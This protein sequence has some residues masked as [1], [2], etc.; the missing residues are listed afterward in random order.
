MGVKLDMLK[1]EEIKRIAKARGGP[2]TEEDAAFITSMSME[3]AVDPFSVFEEGFAKE[4][5][6]SID[7]AFPTDP[8]D[9]Q[10]FSW[11]EEA[12]REAPSAV[13]LYRKTAQGLV[14]KREYSLKEYE[15][16][17]EGVQ[18]QSWAG[19]GVDQAKNMFP[20]YYPVKMRGLTEEVPFTYPGLTGDTIAA[21][22][23]S[24]LGLPFEEFKVKYTEVLDRLQEDNPSLALI[25][26]S[27]VIGRSSDERHV[28][29]A[30]D[31]IDTLALGGIPKAIRASRNLIEVRRAF[32]DLVKANGTKDTDRGAILAATGN[33]KEA[34]VF[35]VADDII[36]GMAETTPDVTR[37]ILSDLPEFFQT[38]A[39]EIQAA[40]GSMREAAVRL[41]NATATQGA[42]L[43]RL[44]AEQGGVTRVGTRE[45]LEA[46][47]R[48]I[49]KDLENQFPGLN[50]SYIN[51]SAPLRD[52]VT[53][54]LHVQFKFGDQ[55]A[56]YFLDRETAH[57][58]ATLNKLTN[59]EVK[60]DGRGFY[61]AIEKPFKETD[62]IVRDGLIETG[63]T[64]TPT[65]LFGMF[66][67]GRTPDDTLSKLQNENRK[68]STYVPQSFL[69]FVKDTSENIR[70]MRKGVTELDAQGNRVSANLFGNKKRMR[71]WER[72]V[73]LG[74]TLD[75]KD[76]PGMKGYFYKS[77]MEFEE[78]F[79]QNIGRMPSQVETAAYFE[80]V[81]LHEIDRV[82]RASADYRNKSRV[83][84]EKHNFGF[85]D[86]EGKVVRSPDFEGVR[87]SKLP[88][89]SEGVI[90]IVGKTL[91]ETQVKQVDGL[92]KA[93]AKELKDGVKE[94]RL[95]VIEVYAPE[96][97]VFEG[98]AGDARVRWVVTN[99]LETKP[100]SWNDQVPRRG[101]GHWEYDYDFYI[102]Q[103][104]M[105]E[106]PFKNI[107][108]KWYEGDTTVMPMSIRA[109]GVEVSKHLDEVR[110]LL[111]AGK[112]K[113]AE[114]YAKANLHVAPKEVLS[115]FKPSMLNGKKK[116]PRLNLD[117][118]IQLVPKD[119]MIV[120]IDNTLKARHGAAF[121]D[122]TT[123]GSLNK[124][125]QVQF[126]GERD[127]YELTTLVDNGTR[128]KPLYA[129]EP[130][131]M[132]DPMPMMNRALQR[133]VN[134][135]FMDDYKT[136]SVE[137][138]IKEAEN[139]L[140][141]NKADLRAN[142][143]FHFHNPRFLNGAPQD[144]VDALKGAHYQIE[145]LIGKPT[146]L[147][148]Q[149]HSVSQKL[150]DSIYERVGGRAALLTDAAL[151]KTKDPYTYARSMAFHA[152]LGL[153][154]WVQL[155]V[156][157]Q[158]MAHI[159]A[160]AGPR[161]AVSGSAASVA[162]L[163]VRRNM[164]PEIMKFYDDALVKMS[165]PGMVAWKPGEFTEAIRTLDQTGFRHVQMGPL[166][167][168]D[169]AANPRIVQGA[170]GNFLD[171]GTGFFRTGEKAVRN[172]AWF[173]AYKEF[174]RDNPTKR[175]TNQVRNQILN[176]A[177]DL[178]VNMS[179]ASNSALHKGIFSIPFQFLTYQLRLMEQMLPF[180]GKRLTTAEKARVYAV[181]GGLYGFP[182]ATNVTGVPFGDFIRKAALE[183]NVDVHESWIQGALDGLPSMVLSLVTGKQYNVGDRFGIQ[184][185]ET[186]REF[187]RGDRPWWELAGGAAFSTLRDT[188]GHSDGFVQAMFSAIRGDGEFDFQLEDFVDP[189]K[190]I[191]TVNNA[192]RGLAAIHTG[193][194]MSRKEIYLS[195]VSAA[196]AFFMTAV[197][198]QPQQVADMHLMS[199]AMKDQKE[200]E[201]HVTK[202][203][204]L[205]FRRGLDARKVGNLEQANAYMKRAF[206]YLHIGGLRQDMW[207]AAISRATQGNESLIESMEWDFYQEKVSPE[208]QEGAKEQLMRNMQ[209]RQGEQ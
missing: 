153:F 53:N 117:E 46:G 180:A 48:A 30:F 107:I 182:V 15:K 152:K 189:F 203:F 84:T 12:K 8:D 113:D 104:K 100:L 160:V 155:L 83:G 133:I 82:L 29:N 90:M 173:S 170:V 124:Q 91:K 54:T 112:T 47:V 37:R 172:V 97:R 139:F 162:A 129:W 151:S 190:A 178:Y 131:K 119:K 206:V 135:R 31:L 121:R 3:Q 79:Q 98:I 122:G 110:K 24:L 106:E 164:S 140:D 195:D 108:R 38:M 20:W 126:T 144:K 128:G 168:I 66:T 185:F 202:Q 163:L 199:W 171:A 56:G 137:H 193:R 158:S 196:N 208:R 181:Y 92:S 194:W 80:H 138:W 60:G 109:Q 205:E 13:D 71:E 76:N 43:T 101:G 149:L 115:W 87:R 10:P 187:T 19:W 134:S 49:Q 179:R 32:K 26:A 4:F 57:M 17:Y 77:P 127:S 204:V 142:P 191:S 51:A 36:E 70:A 175:I 146:T 72:V 88:L 42:K 27:E 52:P 62:N 157:M 192:W 67:K 99:S 118:P 61:V 86:E 65:S 161:M 34:A 132:V 167:M 209:R 166:A 63:Q 45:A 14:A 165:Y 177:D 125:N 85:I 120:D 159:T 55:N 116:P 58:S 22:A 148:A 207:P 64:D 94:G 186:L 81:R 123:R 102:K 95:Q 176:R 16:R 69:E 183:N 41:A 89:G 28:D 23:T 7:T 200:L 197:G 141:V 114:A 130:A 136:F 174:R 6:N 111:K 75:D 73:K 150:V 74:R 198:L 154:N 105:H 35:K 2:L 18:E 78:A 147:D 156:Q 40:P 188:F 9:I 50:G 68:I 103:A 96:H 143:Y 25:F 201:E 145:Q 169:D 93:L 21:T 59:Y 33:V 11:F 44:M 184:G 5:I 1:Q 39:R